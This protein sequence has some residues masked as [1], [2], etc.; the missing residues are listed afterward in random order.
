ML[1]CQGSREQGAGKCGMHGEAGFRVVA[2]LPGVLA[3]WFQPPVSFSPALLRKI[4][5]TLVA[6]SSNF[7]RGVFQILSRQLSNR[8]RPRPLCNG[9]AR[10]TGLRRDRDRGVGD[11]V[12][13]RRGVDVLDARC[14]I[15]LAP[16]LSAHTMARFWMPSPGRRPPVCE[17]FSPPWL[18]AQVAVPH[19]PARPNVVVRAGPVG[20]GWFADRALRRGFGGDSNFWKEKS[21]REIV[22]FRFA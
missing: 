12:P 22:I 11:S 19:C 14:T 1:P 18:V 4:V 17:S 10:Q 8:G 3:R 20:G 7:C 2:H 21:S 16:V 5:Q 13:G 6:A 15:Y 9:V